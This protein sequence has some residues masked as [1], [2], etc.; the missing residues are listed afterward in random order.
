MG[1]GTTIRVE[2]TSN[3]TVMSNQHFKVR[4]MSL[5]AKGLLSLILSL[6]PDWDYSIAGLT[7]ICKEGYD[8]IN[9]T[10]KELQN[11]G[12]LRI[13]KIPPKKVSEG[14][15]GKYEYVYVINEIS[16]A[17]EKLDFS[18]KQGGEKQGVAFSQ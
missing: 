6:P 2:K 17:P 10:L 16:T 4:N 13:E 12:Y 5:K 1:N 9:T 15:T 11:L 18:K 8:T 7:S 3:Y 14:G